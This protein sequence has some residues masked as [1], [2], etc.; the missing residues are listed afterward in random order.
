MRYS[1]HY[2]WTVNVSIGSP[3]GVFV[4]VWVRDVNWTWE[5]RRPLKIVRVDTLVALKEKADQVLKD[6]QK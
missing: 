5:S 3:Y 4:R 2:A 1:D 6:F